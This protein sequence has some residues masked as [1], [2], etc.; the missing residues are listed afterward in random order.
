M[1]GCVGSGARNDA[2]MG[3]LNAGGRLHGLNLDEGIWTLVEPI[4]NPRAF[5]LGPPLRK[6]DSP[7]S[8]YARGCRTDREARHRPRGGLRHKVW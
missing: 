1:T 3:T 5:G 7:E 4:L 2:P 6:S 8:L